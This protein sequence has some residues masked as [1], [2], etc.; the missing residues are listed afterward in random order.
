MGG[1]G[2]GPGIKGAA[3]RTVV[4]IISGLFFPVAFTVMLASQKIR[5]HAHTLV[6]RKRLR[7]IG[8]RRTG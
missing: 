1:P 8:C 3:I 7:A 2:D 4:P 6:A 5:R